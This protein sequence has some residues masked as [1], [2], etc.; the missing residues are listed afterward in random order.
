MANAFVFCFRRPR[1]CRGFHSLG[2]IAFRVRPDRGRRHRR[3]LFRRL[4]GGVT[5]LR[6]KSYF[7]SLSE[8]WGLGVDSS[9]VLLSLLK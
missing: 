8:E 4:L 7:S 1:S 2:S 5:A 6:L 3:R 9:L